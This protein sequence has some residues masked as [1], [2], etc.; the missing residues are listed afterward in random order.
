MG[1]VRYGTTG[2]NNRKN[3][4][5]IEVNHQKGKMALAHN[6]NLSNALEL[7]DK[8]EL[9]G[10][11]FHTTSDTETIAY[12]ITRERLTA[13]S[14]EEAVS[15][16]MTSLEGAYSLILMSSA[17]MI[18]VRD[19]YGFRPLCY[20]KMP[21]GSYVIASESCALTS[22]GAELIRDLLPGEILV[23]SEEGVE[24]R[25][26]TAARRNRR[27]VYLNI[28]ILQDRTLSLIRSLY[29]QQEFR[30]GNY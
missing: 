18:A 24:S 19:P 5:P 9:S 12:M 1:H 16:A 23:F 3:C 7:R 13:P 15:R 27:P 21:D 30:L 6:G 8:L 14:I 25:G 4:Q 22:V 11:I 29:Q 2:R 10:A 28:F 26:N 17:K 20:G